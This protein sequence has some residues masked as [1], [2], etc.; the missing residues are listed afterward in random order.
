VLCGLVCVTNLLPPDTSYDFSF[1]AFSFFCLA[2]EMSQPEYDQFLD[3]V[4]EQQIVLAVLGLPVHHLYA[5]QAREIG[6]KMYRQV[7]AFTEMGQ[8]IVFDLMLDMHMCR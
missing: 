6:G 3:P 2:H 4:R 7:H 1:F 5:F 8:E